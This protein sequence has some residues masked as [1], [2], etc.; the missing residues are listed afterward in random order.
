MIKAYHLEYSEIFQ[1]TALICLFGAVAA[2]CVGGS[3]GAEAPG[4]KEN[5]VPQV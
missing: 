3:R 1:L 2:A 4:G 5:P